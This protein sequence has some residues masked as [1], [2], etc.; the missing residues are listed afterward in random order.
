MKKSLGILLL[1]LLANPI[2]TYALIDMRN[3]NF[4]DMWLDVEVKSTGFDLKLQRT[5]NSRTLFHGV[6]GFGWCSDYETVL[7]VTPENTLRVTECGAGAEQEYVPAGYTN[8]EKSKI[9]ATIMTE[10]KKRNKGKPESYFKNLEIDIQLDSELRDEF[11]SQLKIEGTVQA[12]SSYTASGRSNDTLVFKNS[13]Y[14]RSLPSGIKQKFNKAGQLIQMSDRN[15]NTLKL[16]YDNNKLVTVSDTAGNSL[17]FKYDKNRKYVQTVAGPGSLMA[18]YKY[19]GEQLIE[20]KNAWKNTFTYV[21]DD[22]NNITKILYPDKTS[23]ELTYNKDNDWVTSFKDRSGCLETYKYA[24]QAKDPINNYVSEVKKICRGKVTNTSSYEFWH[25]SKKDGSRYLERTLANRNGQIT[26]TVYHETFGRPISITENGVLTKFEYYPDG[27]LKNKVS[28]TTTFAFKY[29][30]RCGKVSEVIAKYSY[31][32]PLTVAPPAGKRAPSKDQARVENRIVKTQ[33]GYDGGRCNPIAAKNSEGQSAEL[34]YDARGRITK[35]IDQS[36][37]I[38]TIAYEERF[39]KPLIVSRPGLGTIKFKYKN[40][41]TVEK[42][43]SD[44]DPI[45]AIQVASTFSNL[46][47]L[48]APATTDTNNI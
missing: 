38:V 45:V 26:E 21:Y 42:F 24:D 44:D 11:A 30:Q 3:A 2:T 4:S 20:V 5:Y 40:D 6:F 16:T 15:G 17:Q 41:G 10:I 14:L 7:R 9:I 19:K 33:F 1:L 34:S 25:K 35:I 43:D 37:K 36:K 47:E 13:E 18:T 32:T 31:S 23:V 29:D 28:P 27:M 48:I 22:L 12:G 46:L 39:G 8:Q